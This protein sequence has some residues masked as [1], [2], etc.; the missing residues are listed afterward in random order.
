M[1]SRESR[2]SI[3]KWLASVQPKNVAITLGVVA[4]VWLIVFLFAGPGAA[5]VVT[6]LVVLWGL[7]GLFIT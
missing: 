4:A 3:V 7:I 1:A 2:E 6:L 5:T